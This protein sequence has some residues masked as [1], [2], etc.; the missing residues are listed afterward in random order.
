[1]INKSR[2]K[3][4][5]TFFALVLALSLP[6]WILGYFATNLTR[7]LPI[8]LPI[9][10]LMAFC[11]M[12]AAIIL[13]YQ[14]DKT[15][16]I[17]TLFKQVFDY[18]KINNKFW[19]I[20]IILFV[21]ITT[22]LSLWYKQLNSTLIQVEP[23]SYIAIVLFTIAFFIAAT[24]EELGWSG[25]ITNRLQVQ[26]GPFNTSILIGIFWAIWHIIPYN[27][28]GQTVN[29]IIWQCIGTVFLRII[30]VWIFN[31][32]GGSVFG[33]IVFHTMLNISPYLIPN[34]GSN[35]DPY[36]F[37]ILLLIPIL[38]VTIYNSLTLK[39]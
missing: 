27:Q 16:G 33:I 26:F 39:V 35:Y 6:F 34:Y 22:I 29:W 14:E 23:L 30:M 8:R 28:A 9:S 18:N 10:A 13:V 24:G 21:P 25:Y 15:K 31:K 11:P 5:F 3:T 38:I 1:M 17:Q 7:N 12:I 20:I 2:T 36:I 4:N 37:A 19:L 32:T